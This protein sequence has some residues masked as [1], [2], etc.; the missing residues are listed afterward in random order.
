MAQE[1]GAQSGQGR[2]TQATHPTVDKNNT[3]RFSGVDMIQVGPG[4]GTELKLYVEVREQ[5]CPSL[6]DLGRRIG[7]Q[8][9]GT[10]SRAVHY[11]VQILLAG[12]RHREAGKVDRT[13]YRVDRV[14][15]PSTGV[16]TKTETSH[17]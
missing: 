8:T 2:R 16:S 17:V 6:S 14:I 9:Q 4:D 12:L 7:R 13:E 11:M 10:D 5:G 15:R 3:S 1:Q